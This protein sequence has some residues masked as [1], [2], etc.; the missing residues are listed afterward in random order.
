MRITATQKQKKLKYIW[1]SGYW[2]DTA[3][4]TVWFKEYVNLEVKGILD[5][6][7]VNMNPSL[8]RV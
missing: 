5:M 1:Q 6:Q 3:V 7:I 4:Y 2:N 8:L